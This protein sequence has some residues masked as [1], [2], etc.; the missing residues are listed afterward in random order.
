[1]LSIGRMPPPLRPNDIERMNGETLSASRTT[2]TARDALTAYF[3][4]AH[5]AQ[6]EALLGAAGTMPLPDASR[7]VILL[8]GILGSSLVDRD[9]LFDQLVWINL[10]ELLMLG[11]L[12]RLALDSTGT[13]DA[14]ANT[15]I[16]AEQPVHLFYELLSLDLRVSAGV[17]V[18]PVGFD[19][20]RDIDALAVE[21]RSKIE[22]LAAGDP[23]RRF[24]IVAHSMGAL[25]HH[26]Y[27]QKFPND[28]LTRIEQVIYMAPPF[29]GSF[30]P[31]QI[32]AGV[33]PLVERFGLIDP[34]LAAHVQSV[35]STFPSL[36][37]MLPDP[38]RIGG[39]ALF[40]PSNWN[41]PSIS[42]AHLADVSGFQSALNGAYA[43]LDRTSILLG[44]ARSTPSSVVLPGFQ[45][46]SS[47]AGDGTVLAE[48]AWLEGAQGHYACPGEHT[49]LPLEGDVRSGIIS[50]LLSR[51]AKA[52]PLPQITTAPQHAA[53]S[54]T[55]T[56][57]STSGDAAARRT[58]LGALLRTAPT[59]EAVR[60]IL[61]IDE[62][63]DVSAPRSR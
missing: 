13:V 12:A 37:Q 2:G 38:G 41:S 15:R 47:P 29:G 43:L 14:H 23:Q 57:P 44:N 42:S 21:L 36:Y 33:H 62:A 59:G 60:W 1:M 28:A 5:E 39:G 18:E 30:V 32:F 3:G 4:T 56:V 16:V 35:F 17:Q 51:G 7:T 49:L 31:A 10:P 20:R 63:P 61:G 22:T 55:S 34:P 9:R 8:P 19:W 27:A 48:S 25:V 50:L 11:A 52:D 26:R 24:S 53:T 40:D 46:S 6:A 58:E 45:F 54:F